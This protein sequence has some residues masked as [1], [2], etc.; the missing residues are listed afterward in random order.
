MY[1]C[2]CVASFCELLYYNWSSKTLIPSP[3]K[4]VTSS[5]YKLRWQKTRLKKWSSYPLMMMVL[6]L[7]MKHLRPDR[8][9][10]HFWVKVRF[11]HLG[12]GWLIHLKAEMYG[13]WRKG[14]AGS[15]WQGQ[16]KLWPVCCVICKLEHWPIKQ[17]KSEGCGMIWIGRD[18]NARPVSPPALGRDTFPRLL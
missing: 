7:A 12:K 15:L 13:T 4:S 11:R 18:L 14:K 17:W 16:A 1:I 2:V 10:V 9:R 5:E 3:L 6:C 8:S